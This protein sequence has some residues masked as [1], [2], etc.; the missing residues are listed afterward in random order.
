MFEFVTGQEIDEAYTDTKR[1][2]PGT[3]ALDENG[4]KYIFIK[5][6]KGD[7]SE[8]GTSGRHV[9]GLDTGHDRFEA[10]ADSNS[11]TIPAL[12]NLPFGQLQPTLADEEYGFSHYYGYSR[13][14]TIT[15]GSVAQGNRLILVSTAAGAVGPL[16]GNAAQVGTALETDSG[17]ALAAGEVFLDIPL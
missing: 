2:R 3:K 17:T 16:T 1:F 15:N 12:I 5:Y 9:C 13:K 11:S 10:T 7:G 4:N 14:A 8:A 6:N